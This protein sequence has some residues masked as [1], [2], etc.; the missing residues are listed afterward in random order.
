M[1]MFGVGF[2][3]KLVMRAVLR[4]GVKPGENV[5]LAYGSTTAGELERTK[6][7]NAVRNLRKILESTGVRVIEVPMGAMSFSEDVSAVV[8]HLREM[9]PR[10]IIVALG[11]GMR[12]VAFVLLFS[13][14]LY[15][16]LFN[17]N[18]KI[19]VHAAREDG[20]YDVTVSLNMAKLLLGHRELETLCL[21]RGETLRRDEVVRRLSQTFKIK[22]S[23]FY[24]LLSRM[25][26]DEL[27]AV[28][29]GVIKVTELGKAIAVVGCRNLGGGGS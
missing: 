17:K 26:E 2:D 14:L 28:E 3:E 16:E 15:R 9:P 11:S 24:R 23:T 22:P 19:M 10:R 8:G 13:S 4:V 12:Y 18:A 7:E 1:Y 21:L 25:E 6:V 20:L 5:I 27:I 29:D